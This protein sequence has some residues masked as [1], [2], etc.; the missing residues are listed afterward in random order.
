MNSM[1]ELRGATAGYGTRTVLRAIDLT[2]AQ[3]S[4]VVITGANGSGKSTLLKVIGG[5][6]PARGERLEVQGIPLDCEANRRRVRRS[7]GYL[8]Q[9][10]SAPRFAVTV[11]ESVLLGRWGASFG[12][13]RRSGAADWKASREALALTGTLELA[14]RDIRTLSG[15]Q[16]QRIAL[17]RALVR[18]ADV[19]LMDE[20][21]TFLDPDSKIG[22]VNLVRNLHEELGITVIMV[23][24][25]PIAVREGDRVLTLEDGNLQELRFVQ[26][27]T[28]LWKR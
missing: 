27:G 14:D 28:G 23:S 16:R 26:T 22:F 7:I 19:V 15:G 11:L 25:E 2:I 3:R 9:S 18:K 24:H 20:P 10:Q 5:T 1:V 4:F 8:A 13:F 6:L 12:F 17:A 21:T